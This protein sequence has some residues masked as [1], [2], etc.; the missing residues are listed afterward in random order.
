VTRLHRPALAACV[1]TLAASSHVLADPPAPVSD[2]Q[3][4]AAPSPELLDS[5][6]DNEPQ[7]LADQVALCEIPAPPFKEQQR[8]EAFKGRLAAIGVENVRIDAVG[9]VLGEWAG[10]DPKP[11]VVLSAHLD[12]VF[13]EGTDVSVT[14]DGPILKGP[15]IV[16]DC[17]GL[18]V[19]LG[20]ARAVVDNAVKPHG[21]IVFVG[22]VGEEGPGNLRGVRHLFELEL[23]DRVDYF[24]SID[25]AGSD[26]THGAVG[27]NRY[28]VTYSGPGGHSL[29][30]FGM[31]NPMHA[32]G[33]AIAKIADFEVTS[34]PKVTFAVSL[35][36]GGT[37]INS[38][39]HDATMGVDMRSA[40]PD[41]LGRL[42]ERFRAAVE[43]AL[44][45]ERQRWQSDVELTVKVKSLGV[46][47]AGWQ[48]VD[49]PIVVA[50]IEAARA[51]GIEPHLGTASTDANIPISLGIP[52]VTLDGGGEGQ[53][54][55]SPDTETFD[56]TDS[57]R[58]TQWALLL[59]L[60]LANSGQG[61]APSP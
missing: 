45:E 46:R 2:T 20:V 27:S 48:P 1:V 59:T 42:D 52:A 31:P 47:P 28:Q 37:S 34:N 22:T 12:T 40:D 23:K 4:V 3:V 19:V 49:A 9:N 8:A 24:I 29:H 55:H 32:L 13:P 56:T 39:P 61:S 10:R 57:H 26:L 50:A 36:E 25:G 38:I 60:A 14:R 41:A 18:A 43:E 44:A 58:G 15:G 17:R 21:R 30:A 16:D 33:R 11:V 5:V 7:T 35:L 53:G 6:R 51:A 54:A